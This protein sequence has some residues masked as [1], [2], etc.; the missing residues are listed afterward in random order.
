[1]GGSLLRIA[2][3]AARWQG[4]SEVWASVG[5]D[6]VRA[7]RIGIAEGFR[8]G[9]TNAVYR[10]ERM[11]H[12]PLADGA[13]VGLRRAGPA[14]REALA[15]AEACGP[16]PQ[17]PVPALLRALDDP[18]QQVY[19]GSSDGEAAG[20][21]VIDTTEGWVYG[22]STLPSAR[23]RGFGAAL[24]SRALETFWREQPD[25]WLGLTVRIDNLTAINLYRRQ[26]FEPWIVLGNWSR[27]L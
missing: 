7:E 9:E 22:L 5:R 6:N 11:R 24:L 17:L 18:A 8:K 26:G 4:M 19:V 2:L 23:A 15:L 10:L 20:I 27:A 25:R 21:L 14:D 12:R 1:V 3:R 16:T 13:S